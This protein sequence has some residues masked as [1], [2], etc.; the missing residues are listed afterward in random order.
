MKLVIA[1]SRDLHVGAEGIDSVFKLIYSRLNVRPDLD[2][3]VAGGCP[4]GPDAGAKLFA[5][6][7]GY[8]YKE[9]P[10]DW[11]RYGK[12][13]G[14]RRNRQ[15]AEYGDALLLIWD[16]KSRGSMSMKTEMLAQ[17]KPVYEIIMQVTGEFSPDPV[18]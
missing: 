3:I 2:E 4:T 18:A 17:G 15:M 6:Q 5:L 12:F 9:F 7:Y 16:G 1:G 11:D 14:P 10:A 13:A 8:S